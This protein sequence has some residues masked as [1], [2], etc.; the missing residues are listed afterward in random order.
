MQH[1]QKYKNSICLY[2]LSGASP[3]QLE[4]NSVVQRLEDFLTS[5]TGWR[6]GAGGG[7]G[8]GGGSQGCGWSHQNG[9]WGRQ[10]GEVDDEQGHLDFDHSHPPVADPEHVH[11]SKEKKKKKGF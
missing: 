5:E 3:S 4:M 6:L 8:G 2:C 11:P 7:G 9:G 10:L 1:L